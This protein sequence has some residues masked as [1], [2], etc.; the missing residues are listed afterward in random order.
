MKSRICGLGIV[1]ILAV[2]LLPISISGVGAGEL[3]PDQQELISL[4]KVDRTSLGRALEGQDD[5]VRALETLAQQIDYDFKAMKVLFEKRDFCCLAKLLGKRGGFL[6][7]PGFEKICGGGSAEFWQSVWKEDLEINFKAVSIVVSGAITRQP[8]PLCTLIEEGSALKDQRGNPIFYNAVAYLVFEFH[9][10][11]KT[12][13]KTSP[14]YHNQ[15]G[16][17]GGTYLH[18]TGCPWG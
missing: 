12:V 16:G 15:T 8:V 13:P 2:C 9:I 5:P 14:S 18:K 3:T 11:P 7:T 6:T 1:L 10:V 4:M 17:G